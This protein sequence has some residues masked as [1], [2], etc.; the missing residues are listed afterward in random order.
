M[1]AK[2]DYCAVLPEDTF[3]EPAVSIDPEEMSGHLIA[4]T[5]GVASMVYEAAAAGA[6]ID[7]VFLA[8]TMDQIMSN[9]DHLEK[10]FEWKRKR[11]RD[12]STV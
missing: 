3:L 12:T 4:R 8:S 5:R 10:V 11:D 9:L 2:N 7:D 6:I 1:S